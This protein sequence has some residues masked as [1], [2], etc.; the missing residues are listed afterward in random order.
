MAPSPD[1]DLDWLYGRDQNDGR[2]AG[3][4]PGDAHRPGRSTDAEQ[5]PVRGQLPTRRRRATPRRR[6]TGG[7]PSTPAMDTALLPMAA[8]PSA[9]SRTAAGPTAPVVHP[10]APPARETAEEAAPGTRPLRCA[11]VV[12]LLD[13]SSGL[14]AVPVYAWSQVA[15]GRRGTRAGSG[16]PTSRARR[17]CWSDR[18]PA[19][20]C[21]RPSARSSVPG[22]PPVS[23]PTR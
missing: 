6:S 10:A 17:S 20:A 1:D 5:A 14:V 23:G 13:R 8:Q 22:A 11:A 2:P 18:T 3:A 21:P 7:Y 9:A 15:P 4:D 12:I 16:R 19:R